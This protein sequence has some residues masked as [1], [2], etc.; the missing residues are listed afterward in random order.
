MTAIV[1]RNTT[2][3]MTSMPRKLN[4]SY[5]VE[6]FQRQLTLPPVPRSTL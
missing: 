4:L 1:G 6:A 2:P 3:S 5:A